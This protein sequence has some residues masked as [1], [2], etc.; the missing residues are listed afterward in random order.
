M[1][2]VT[3]T[4]TGPKTGNCLSA[5]AASINGRDD[6]DLPAWDGEGWWPAFE[7]WLAT[8]GWAV[9]YWV[10]EGNPVPAG[11][12]IGAGASPRFPGVL[13]AVVTLDG[14]LE[15]DPHPSRA[16]IVGKFEDWMVLE[17]RAGD[18]GESK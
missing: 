5:C 14:A 18:D 11:L 16:G 15:W 3:Q 17:P 12:A 9:T 7:S 10:A 4:D 6:I 2:R 13:H 1:L 8:L